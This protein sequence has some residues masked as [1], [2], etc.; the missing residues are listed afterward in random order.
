MHSRRGAFSL[1]ELS[2]VLVILGLLVGGILA[3]QSLI[4]AAELR[5]VSSDYQRFVT[6]IH[7]F[8]DKYLALP[9]DIPNATNFWEIRSGSSSATGSDLACH[10]VLNVSAGTC[11]GDANGILNVNSG[12][13]SYATAERFL[14]W[15]HLAKAGLVEG[16]YSG[17]LYS[18]AT[19]ESPPG[20]STPNAPSARL[21]GVY[22]N[23]SFLSSSNA[24]LLVTGART[25]INVLRPRSHST[26]YMVLTPSEAWNVDTK[27]DDGQPGTGRVFVYRSTQ[28]AMLGCATSD[29]I[30]ASYSLTSTDQL[31]SPQMIY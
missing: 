7:A 4:R 10:Q 6:A 9:G 11:N 1:V 15:Q 18:T 20:V 5:S 31:C 12:W 27:M 13:G 23:T 19:A 3:G 2:I 16:D 22:W 28:A 26:N 29:A 8:R 21:S 25:N 30:D 24:A 17:S 14:F